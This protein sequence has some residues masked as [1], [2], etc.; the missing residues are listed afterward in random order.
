MA[1]N[2]EQ[3][4]HGRAHKVQPGLH[5]SV[6]S[7]CRQDGKIR[8][9]SRWFPDFGLCYMSFCTGICVSSAACSAA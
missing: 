4:E 5:T 9:H 8:S 1:S 6:L 7:K 2:P 3:G